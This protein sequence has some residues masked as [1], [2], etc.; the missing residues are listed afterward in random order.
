MFSTSDISI[1]RVVS[2]VEA[3]AI[4]ICVVVC[5]VFIR[6]KGRSR[7]P[8]EK[9]P[10]SQPTPGRSSRRRDRGKD[11]DSGNSK[12]WVLLIAFSVVLL[13]VSIFFVFYSPNST[14]WKVISIVEA[15]A[16][17]FSLICIVVGSVSVLSYGLLIVMA[18][19]LSLVSITSTTLLIVLPENQVSVE[20]THENHGNTTE[21]GNAT[22]HGEEIIPGEPPQ[23]VPYEGPNYSNSSGNVSIFVSVSLFVAMLIC[24][25]VAKSKS[26]SGDLVVTVNTFDKVCI[27]VSPI[28]YFVAWCIGFSNSLSIVLLSVSGVALLYSLFLSI[29]HNKTVAYIIL[30]IVAKL[31]IFVLINLLLLLLLIII[32]FSFFNSI[33]RSSERREEK[34]YMEYDEFLDKIVCYRVY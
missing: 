9:G 26:K 29:T 34:W 15:V 4:T 1:L 20:P 12:L 31:F 7:S 30:S 33:S 18:M 10:D 13:A 11:K 6:G 3:I 32:I 27:I 2:V 17:I 28:L 5:Y 24:Y 14:A 19:S 25:F 22:E 16:V 21:S 23:P 8:R